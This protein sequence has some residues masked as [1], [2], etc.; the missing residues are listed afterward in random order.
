[1]HGIFETIGLVARY[2]STV[3]I[4]GE[5]G[6]G[7]ELVARAIHKASPRANGPL[8]PVNCAALSETLLESDL[9][10]HEKGAFTG[11]VQAKPGLF[12]VAEGGTIF[13]DEIGELPLPTQAKL[14]RVL[15]DGSFRRV[16]GTQ[17]LRADVRV[18]AATNKALEE[19]IK[20]GRFREDLF[21]RL[22]VVEIEL[23][24]LRDRPQDIPLLATHFIEKVTAEGKPAKPFSPEAMEALQNHSWPG[25]VRELENCV[26]R[27]LVLCQRGDAI[28][29]KYLPPAVLARTEAYSKQ[30]MTKRPI[31]KEMEEE[32]EKDTITAA[33][34]RHRG[35]LRATAR[36]LGVPSA[37]FQAKID[38]HKL[39][40]FARQLRMK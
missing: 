34:I 30:S 40:P 25:N 15:E 5:S 39:R 6:T 2:D 20:A 21:Y 37:T 4:Q 24:P 32:M 11:A 38:K 14:L 23:S 29:P 27:A 33:L 9:F 17:E 12:E 3:L 10:G 18:V 7:K 31:L 28:T 26:E 13:L 35:N 1:M 36:S 8:V 22:N 16:G 19:E